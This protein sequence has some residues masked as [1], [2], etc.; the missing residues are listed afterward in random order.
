MKVV[1]KKVADSIIDIFTEQIKNGE[2]KNGDRLPNLTDYAK[3]LGVSRLSVRE[4]IRTLE[5]LGAVSSS[6]KVGTVVICDDVNKWA[7]PTVSNIFDDVDTLQQLFDA[8]ILFEGY[9]AYEC[10]KRSDP[11][12]VEKLKNIIS[13]QEKAY[14]E[15][16]WNTFYLYDTQFHSAI[17]EA[18]DNMFIQRVYIELIESTNESVTDIL[19]R[20]PEN[21]ED[22]LLIHKKIFN[23]IK[24][25]KP[26]A[27]EKYAHQHLRRLKE[28]RWRNSA[29]AQPAS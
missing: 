2:L 4:A 23:A 26:A 6:P 12:T 28:Y 21:I 29:V 8:R 20:S 13:Y 19:R 17:A 5:Q 22:S 7:Y 24:D 27:A 11:A 18:C 10:A 25:G 9:F 15:G 16:D 3:Q 14:S 1:K